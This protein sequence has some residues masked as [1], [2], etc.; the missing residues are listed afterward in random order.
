MKYIDK[1]ILHREALA[2][3]RSFLKDCYAHDIKHPIPSP[4]DTKGAY[5]DFKKPI[6]RDGQNGWK[7]LL[8]QEQTC[9]GYPRC[10]YCMRKLNTERGLINYEHVI[11]RT[12]TDASQHVECQYYFDHAP[13]L[14]DHVKMGD[15]FCATS[16]DTVDDIDR[17][18]QM[19]H[20]TALSNLLVAC[21]GKH[22][23]FHT[24]GCCCNGARGDDKLLPLMLMPEADSAA[25]YD[26]NGLLSVACDDGTWNKT[27]D[28]LNETT[29]SEIR[30][31]WCRLSKVPK[32]V[33]TADSMKMS[34]RI[35][36]F[37]TA[38]HTNNFEALP[39]SVKRYIGVIDGS[40]DTYWRLLLAYDWFYYYPG[41]ARQRYTSS[42]TDS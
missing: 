25:R 19:P 39:Q 15:V 31:V 32:E 8:L 27:I 34:E 2:I 36:W 17:E 20:T 41:Y 29:L 21:N 37:K 1:Y 35:A 16:F 13:A 22:D 23:S 26:A 3:N 6:Y 10:C 40:D 9:Y 5:E 4:D 38:Y 7:Q 30:A 12:L 11:P 28:E 24:T 14:H 33:D 42:C 18:E